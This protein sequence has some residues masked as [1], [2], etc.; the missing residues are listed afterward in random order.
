MRKYISKNVGEIIVSLRTSYADTIYHDLMANILLHG[1]WKDN[2]TGVR[3]LS[4]FGSQL[5]FKNILDNFPLITTKKIHWKSVVGELLWFLSGST[6][7]FELKEKYG[8]SIWDEWG[9][10][11]TGELGPVY[12]KQW[13]KWE[14]PSWEDTL[15]ESEYQPIYINQI[16]QVIDKLKSNPDDRRLIVSAWNVAEIDQMALP[17]C[18]W[19]FQLYSILNDDKERELSMIMN[20]RS[21][22]VFLG[23]P[24]NIA[25]YALLLQMIAQ[26]VN[27][28]PNELIINAGDAHIYEDHISY[29]KEQLTRDTMAAPIVSLNPFR[30]NLF[31][32]DVN[33]IK[34]I[35]YDAH[36]N[37]KGV[38]VAI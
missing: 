36:P 20:I 18:H 13:I 17:P 3:T 22:D 23:G 24:L 35:N 15:Y 34:L 14:K 10:N 4:I 6:N 12:G 33:D 25:E 2:R 32:F 30:N 19:S 7:K 9:N 31:E 37:W 16:Q 21:W 27:M 8:V 11:E 5:K 28:N 29:V 1:K 26:C 38:P